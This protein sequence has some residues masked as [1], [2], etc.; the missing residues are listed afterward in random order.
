MKILE[1]KTWIGAIYLKDEDGYKIILKSLEHYKRRL[2]TI[3]NSPEVKN[4]AAMFGPLL[5]QQAL[6]TLPKIDEINKII[7]DAL[8]D[9]EKMELVKNNISFLESA[10]NCYQSDIQKARDT[11][12]EY[13]VKLIEDKSNVEEDWNKISIALKKIKEFQ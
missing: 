2:K 10:L 11:N 13:F 8:E 9:H 5:H 7:H 3:G 4:A 1:D 12:D 6:K